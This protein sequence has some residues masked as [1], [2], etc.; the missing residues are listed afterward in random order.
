MS[1]LSVKRHVSD[2][3]LE[4]MRQRQADDLAAVAARNLAQQH[5]ADVEDHR[6]RAIAA[7]DAAVAEAA[8]A[9]AT[10]TGILVE[11]VGA[12]TAA[13][14]AGA[15]PAEIR[16]LSRA[17]PQAPISITSTARRRQKRPKTPGPS[18]HI[19]RTS[20]GANTPRHAS[21]AEVAL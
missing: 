6:R 16:R 1:K 14:L 18:T 21:T 20:P 19:E 11:R 17:T 2:D 8:I 12:D 15:S 9:L 10:A 4:Q 3:Q 13:E 5:L 7:E